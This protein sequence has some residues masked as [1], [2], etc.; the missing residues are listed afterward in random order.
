MIRTMEAPPATAARTLEDERA[1]RKLRLAG[2]FRLFARYDLYEGAAGHI[3]ARDPERSDHY[4][5]NPSDVHWSRMQPSDLL[6]IDP[7]GHVA[8]G[9]GSLN[10][11]AIA[12]HGQVLAARPDIVSVA[13]SHSI[14][15]KAWST[16]GRLLDPLTQDSCAFYDDHAL[17]PFSGI[18]F[19]DR[20]GEHIAHTMGAM[21]AAI[22]QNHG[23]LTVGGSVEEAAWW[24]VSMER[25]CRVQL[26]AEAAGHPQVIDASTAAA[27]AAVQGSASVG[28]LQFNFLWQMIVAEHP[29]LGS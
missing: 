21:K 13:H 2:A 10:P 12:I 18:V 7:D 19:D 1:H 17:V 24:F 15:G 11:A 20:E 6:L 28:L 27:T 26:L 22:L 9:E 23:L 8:Q 16:L 5:L 3:S 14:H 25:Q 4:W 29:D